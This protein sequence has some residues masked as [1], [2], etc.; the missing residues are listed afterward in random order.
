MRKIA[1][2]TAT[3]AEY[4][5]LKPL[6]QQINADINLELQLIVTGTHLEE[7][8]D[9]TYKEIEQDFL[10]DVKIK[11]D[12]EENSNR[13]NSLA[14]AQLQINLTETF[15]TLSPDIVVILGDRYEM[16]SVASTATLLQIPLAHIHGGEVTEGA[17]DDSIRHAI[18]K[19]SHLHFCAAEVYRKRILQLGEEPQRVYNVGSLGV[20]NIQNLQLLSREDFEVS[21]DFSLK[22]CNLLITYHPET[23]SP[24]SAQEQMQSI[25]NALEQ[26]SKCGLIF[27]KANADAGG[28]VINA[29]IDLFVK[30]HSNS[31]AFSSLGQ[32]R[33]FSALN[34]VDA[35]VG[36]SS[37]GILEVPSFHIPTINI[38]ERQKGRVMAKSIL[39]T[40]LETEA[41][42]QSIKKACEK[43]FVE[44][45]ETMK[46]PFEG[47]N[48]SFQIKELLKNTPLEALRVKKFQDL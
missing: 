5:L 19:L 21:L 10:I 1:V 35:V 43:R 41:I 17:M 26:F 11:M 15:S 20:E 16:L 37:S 8:F 47:E 22:K 28:K 23:L 12:L 7:D 42:V 40:A 39:N 25:L 44:E 38:G 18:T 13:A 2:I 34:Y 45:L 48:C 4:G 46:S 30:E 3:R 9:L 6:L 27:T 24:L 14:M 36:N 32:L 29:M 31:I 33:Y